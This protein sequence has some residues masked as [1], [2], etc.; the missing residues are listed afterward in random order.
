[1]QQSAQTL[2]LQGR[3]A[4]ALAAFE[5]ELSA[6][7][8]APDALFGRAT[9]LK[10]MNRFAEARADYDAVLDR[11]PRALGALNNRGEVLNALGHPD[12]ALKDFEQALALKPD[13]PPAIL[14]LGIALQ[15]LNRHEEALKQFDRVIVVWPDSSDGFFHRALAFSALGDLEGAILNY[16]HVIRLQPASP[17]AIANR[18]T[19]LFSLKRFDEARQGFE[20][21]ETMAPAMSL[22]GQA[23]VA[24]HAC[25]WS[26][27]QDLQTRIADALRQRK[28]APGMLLGY[29]DDPGV[30]LA[31]AKD[32]ASTFSLL[33]PLWHHRPFAGR[34]IKLAYVSA[35]FYSHA[36]PRLMAGVFERHDRERFEIIAISFSPDDRSPMQM[37]LM[38]AFNRFI[39]VKKQSEKEIAQ[40]IADLEVDIA[41]DLMGYT[42]DA[43]TGIFAF[44]PA[45][46]Q[47]SYMG[48][49]GTLGTDFHDYIVADDIVAP[50]EA[51]AFFS[52]KIAALPDTYWAT[53]D[54]RAEPGEAPSRAEAGLPEN[55][56]VFC[57][58]NNNWKITPEMFDIWIR[59]M[60]AVPGSVLW[61]LEDN[62]TAAH[63]LRREAVARG[64][65]AERLIFAPRVLPEAHLARHQLADLFL[66]T[67]PYNAHTTASDSLW[68]GVPL[69]TCMGRSFQARVAA[70]ILNAIGLPELITTDLDDYEKLAL[71]L[72]TDPARLRLL[73]EKLAANRR[74]TPLFDTARFTRNLEAAYEKMASAFR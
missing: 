28:S 32:V 65:A 47:V 35:N 29:N 24:L 41:I 15:R 38:R 27:R 71:A 21:L 42:D 31:V 23:M 4:D 54:R 69:V 62:A 5:E 9:A 11:M 7:P 48:Y 52:E 73:R 14:G 16:D 33:G 20:Q 36:M 67:L 25:D 44:R 39:D 56:F 3:F 1:M 51:K 63:N 58:F 57:C 2:L 40:L 61:L 18:A 66:D 59:L 46:V 37:R 55:A 49:P 19:L 13:F 34:K 26:R 12:E 45:P 60:K 17:S 64:V 6:R 22:N 8:G 50:P 43:R 74:S 30:M 53:D 72:A 70:S 10:Q 68:V